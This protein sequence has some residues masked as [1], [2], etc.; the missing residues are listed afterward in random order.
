MKGMMSVV[1]LA[2]GW[3]AG[4]AGAEE[5]VVW[6]AASASPPDSQ[7]SVPLRRVVWTAVHPEAPNSSQ[8]DSGIQQ[9]VWRAAPPE[10][11]APAPRLIRM[12]GESLDLLPPPTTQPASISPTSSDVLP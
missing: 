6:R 11:P 5:K 3:F 8:A 7:S 10:Q 12:S 2:S 4:I 1:L 9:V